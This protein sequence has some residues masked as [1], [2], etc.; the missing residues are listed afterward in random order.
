MH[1]IVVSNREPY[2]H[3]RVK[4]HLRY[5]RTDGGLTSALDPVLCRL[6]GTWVAWG[7]GSADREAVGPEDA[8]AVPPA[9]PAYRLRRVWLT[10]EEVKAG[11][12]GY[13][14]EVLWPL[15]I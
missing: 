7:S 6:G 9:S 15:A 14:N 1:W 12:L 11:Y 2:E 3:R 4:G 10:T 5:D 13:A 8:V